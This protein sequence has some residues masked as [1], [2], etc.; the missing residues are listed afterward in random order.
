MLHK[1]DFKVSRRSRRHD[2]SRQLLK[3]HFAL[4]ARGHSPLPKVSRHSVQERRKKTIEFFL[5]VFASF[6]LAM[7]MVVSLSFAFFLSWS[8]S[9]AIQNIDRQF[10]S[11]SELVLI[12][13]FLDAG[14]WVLVYFFCQVTIFAFS[15]RFLSQTN[16]L[17]T[18]SNILGIVFLAP[19][20][21]PWC[22]PSLDTVF[23]L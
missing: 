19:T 1:N 23:L 14:F 20:I 16:N 18:N 5:F 10:C 15:I 12:K 13:L 4:R 22:T 8:R 7:A 9:R 21:S 17:L 11:S 2:Y 6:L 3:L